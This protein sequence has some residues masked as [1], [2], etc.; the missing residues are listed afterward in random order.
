MV[1]K[2][3]GIEKLLACEKNFKREIV[4]FFSKMDPSFS[5]LI[6]VYINDKEKWFKDAFD[7]LKS[8]VKT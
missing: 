4:V 5:V 7:S 6:S 3:F 2:F 1:Q 8:D